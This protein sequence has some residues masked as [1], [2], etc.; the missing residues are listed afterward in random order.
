MPF[1]SFQ[2]CSLKASVE[3]P[4]WFFYGIPANKEPFFY[5]H[6]KSLSQTDSFN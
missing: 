2:N 4:K 3:K 5:M 1:V 6:L